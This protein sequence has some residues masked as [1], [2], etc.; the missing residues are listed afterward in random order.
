MHGSGHQVPARRTHRGAE[1]SALPQEPLRLLGCLQGQFLNQIHLREIIRQVISLK[2]ILVKKEGI[3]LR[4]LLFGTKKHGVFRKPFGI[5]PQK[6]NGLI[7]LIDLDL[8]D[9]CLFL[10]QQGL[11]GI[12]HVKPTAAG[13]RAPCNASGIGS[14]QPISG[15]TPLDNPSPA[16]RGG[17]LRADHH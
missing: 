7:D 2:V 14:R 13:R 9:S 17:S 10:R 5:H 15:H 1:E 4:E 11:L 3:P 8:F 6:I 12:K 16:P